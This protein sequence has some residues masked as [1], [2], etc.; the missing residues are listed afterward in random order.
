MTIYHSL[1]PDEAR[2]RCR[3]RERERALKQLVLA[4]AKS[5]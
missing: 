2:N 1:N 5:S 3:D 4:P